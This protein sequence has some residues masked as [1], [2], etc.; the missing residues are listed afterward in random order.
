MN[1]KGFSVWEK[2]VEYIVLGVAVVVLGYF[3]W[4]TFTNQASVNK[5]GKVITT[6]NI[7]EELIASANRL[8]PKLNDTAPSPVEIAAPKELLTIFEEGMSAS[9][10]PSAR[11]VFPGVDLTSGFSVN[12]D[13]VAELRS[14]TQPTVPSPDHIRTHQW[15]ATVDE[16]Q[17]DV[18]P[19]LDTLF[20]GP[21]HDATWI[22]VAAEFD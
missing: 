5:N 3:A 1:N 8:S 22:Q 6:E 20:V 15:F 16:T 14:Y 18:I 2:Y 9:L 11:V 21:P 12:Q 13:L 19:E 4:N 17:V 7:D 10:S